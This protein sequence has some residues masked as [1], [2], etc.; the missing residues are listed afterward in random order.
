VKNLRLIVWLTQLGLSVAMPLGGFIWLAVWLRQRLD[1]G[2]WVIIV[3]V[4]LGVICA[5]DGFRMSLKTME[6]MARDKKEDPPP[7]SFN[8][9]D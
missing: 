4:A 9:H 5:V 2:V 7:V 1:W 3:G 6:R 8:E